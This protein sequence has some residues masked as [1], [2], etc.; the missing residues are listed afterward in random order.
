MRGSLP[1]QHPQSPAGLFVQRAHARAC[2][3]PRARAR[4]PTHPV[5][6]TARAA[7]QAL[8]SHSWRSSCGCSFLQRAQSAPRGRPRDVGPPHRRHCHRRW[9]MAAAALA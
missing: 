4:F 8:Q 6:T 7:R 9:Q 1:R 5:T 2:E 3:W